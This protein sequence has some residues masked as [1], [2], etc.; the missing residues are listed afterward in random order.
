[1]AALQSQMHTAVEQGEPLTFESITAMQVEVFKRWYGDSVV[2]DADQMG[3]NWLRVQHHF[4][5][6][7]SYQYATG[8]SAA[9][10]FADAILTEGEPAVKRYLG[11]LSAGSSADPITILKQAGLDMTTPAPVEKAAAYF[12]QL[13]TDLERA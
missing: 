7:Y 11:F 3:V 12:G 2:V 9:A 10:A 5:N 6:F 8:I 13:V 4:M 1:M